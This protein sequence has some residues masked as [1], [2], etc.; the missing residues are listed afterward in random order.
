MG[1]LWSF[2]LSVSVTYLSQ[3]LSEE[4]KIN[5]KIIFILSQVTLGYFSIHAN[6]TL[7]TFLRTVFVAMLLVIA[8]VDYYTKT[9]V[10][11]TLWGLLFI[12]IS[13]FIFFSPLTLKN[14]LLASG[15]GLGL[16]GTI[17]ILAK[18][19]YK[20]EAFGSGDVWLMGAIGLYVGLSKTLW[21]SFLSFY[22]ALAFIGLTFMILRKGHGKTEIPFGPSMVV[23]TLIVMLWEKELIDLYY[24]LIL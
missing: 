20:R 3:W 13:T 11:W 4:E 6:L 18:C 21:I 16:Y 22:V 10:T 23:A 17:Y 7:L 12:S 5:K 8:F 24:W 1:L 9:I 15:L 2:I 19:F 14:H